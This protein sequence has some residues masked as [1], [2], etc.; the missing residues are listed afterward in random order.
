MLRDYVMPNV[1]GA[2]PII[3]PIVNANNFEIKPSLI[4]IMQEAQFGG[5]LAKAPHAHL[6]KFLK[7]CDTIKMNG[8]S[9]DAIRLCFLHFL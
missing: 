9:N 5:G 7:M 3:V 1:N 6:A 2:Q 8:V 4:Q